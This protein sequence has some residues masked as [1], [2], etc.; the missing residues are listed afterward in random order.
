MSIAFH[1]DPSLKRLRAKICGGDLGSLEVTAHWADICLKE[2]WM[3]II[4]YTEITTSC[5]KGE[6]GNKILNYMG[7]DE[8][9]QYN[10]CLLTAVIC[11]KFIVVLYKAEEGFNKLYG[12][13][14]SEK[15][16]NLAIQIAKAKEYDILYECG[17]LCGVSHEGLLSGQ[18]DI[19]HDKGTYDAISLCPEN[20]T[21][22]RNAYIKN[23]SGLLNSNGVYI[24]TSCNWVEDEL[25]Q[26]FEGYFEKVHTI[27]TP[28]FMFGGKVGSVVT[29]VIFKKIPR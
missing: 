6:S 9:E 29:T 13:D 5:Y 28:T 15:A 16:V 18:Y 23:V 27:P 14:Y 25:L 8:K 21:E 4:Q 11:N 19:C 3:G 26:Q 1:P 12:V 24:I 20:P 7:V 17:D 10:S 22:K 2:D